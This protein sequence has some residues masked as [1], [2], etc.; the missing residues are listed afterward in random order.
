M[1]SFRFAEVEAPFH[2]HLV[3]MIYLKVL[4][5]IVAIHRQPNISNRKIGTLGDDALKKL[6]LKTVPDLDL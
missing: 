1:V 2:R 3:P 6:F 4:M 5:N